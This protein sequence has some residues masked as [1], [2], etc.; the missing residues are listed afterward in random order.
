MN[1]SVPTTE[2]L[3]RQL[4]SIL[5]SFPKDWRGTTYSNANLRTR[6][7]FAL[8][9]TQ[10]VTD[11]TAANEDV[12]TSDLEAL[13]NAEDYFRVSSNVST[14]LEI[15]LGAAMGYDVSRV[16]TFASSS[17]PIIAVALTSGGAPVHVY[18]TSDTPT[19]VTPFTTA[20]VELLDKIG[21]KVSFH[22]GSPPVESNDNSTIVLTLN[23]QHTANVDGLIG[24]NVLYIVRPER[25]DEN[26]ILL[27]RKRMSTPLTNPAAEARLQRIAAGVDEVTANLLEADEKSLAEFNAHLQTLSGTVVDPES[28][29]VCFTAGLPS[30]ASLWVTLIERGGADV[31]MCST[32]Y[33]GSNQLMD[34]M[35]SNSKLIKKRTFDIQGLLSIENSIRELLESLDPS[36][37]LPTTVLC[38]EIPTNPDMK[39]PAMPEVAQMLQDFRRRTEK[40]VIMVVDGTFAPNSQ[41]MAKMSELV[42]D[43]PVMV[44]LSMSKSISRG[45]TTAG[46]LICNQT[47]TAKQVLNSVRSTVQFLD[48]GAKKDQIN[49]LCN[50]H[51]GVEKRCELAYNVAVAVGECLQ[52]AVAKFCDGSNMRL[53]FVS[54]EQAA[55]G[56]TTSTFSFN[57]PSPAN[58]SQQIL[59]DLAQNFVSL[60]CAHEKE[61]KP[62]VSFGQDNGRVYATVPATST[63]GAIKEEDK[64][65]QAVGGVQLARLSFPPTCDVELIKKIITESVKQ[66]YTS[67]MN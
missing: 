33:G 49:F 43:L 22:E 51:V 17:M 30:L 8:S 28:N 46:S 23:E 12:D 26:K 6:D 65:K 60:L 66:I 62:C 4:P 11:K 41:V 36:E 16:F 52:E 50:A 7:G 48:T 42:P 14:V 34:L 25:I 38:V 53:A 67:A 39:V 10:M 29:P 63:Q 9:F 32:A 58:A 57:L 37:L 61:F 40:E 47:D 5:R 2:A 45:W 27:I 56:F 1:L 59:A 44:F 20:Q 15:T 55:L 31:L 35:C 24:D 3:Q 18:Y 21:A 54:P 13:G 64:A 19:A